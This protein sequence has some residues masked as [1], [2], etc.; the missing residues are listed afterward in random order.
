M[1]QPLNVWLG[2]VG[3]R[4]PAGLNLI[5]WPALPPTELLARLPRLEWLI[6]E[7]CRLDD[8]EGDGAALMELRLRQPHT[9]WLV[10]GPA[11]PVTPA[12]LDRLERYRIQ[13]Q[14]PADIDA[15]GLARVQQ[16][17]QAGELWLPRRVV[18]AL[19]QRARQQHTETLMTLA[20]RARDRDE[21]RDLRDQQI[22]GM[23]QAGLSPKEI[24]RSL[25]LSLHRV[26]RHLSG[27][28]ALG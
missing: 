22:L 15:A 6:I 18:Q 19:Y 11:L 23:L 13:A 4:A 25:G 28:Q 16:A 12:G 9:C 14:I 20:G 2:P 27:A 1:E 17:L 8:H 26:R 7:S 21:A 24:S 3:P 10:A 5:H